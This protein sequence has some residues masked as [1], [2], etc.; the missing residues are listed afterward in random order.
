MKYLL[1]FLFIVL[2]FR[3]LS[4]S[5]GINN[6]G[7]PA[8]ASAM[9]D[10]SSDQKGILIPRMTLAQRNA[11]PSPATGL[12]IYQTDF[13]I[14]FYYYNGSIWVILGDN[15]GNHIATQNITLGT[16]Y[17]SRS[18]SSNTGLQFTA[19]EAMRYRAFSSLGGT[20]ALGDRLRVD[21]NG[22]LVALGQLGWGII[23]QTGGGERMMW[24][25]YK[26]AFRAGGVDGTAW[27][28]ANIGFYS[29]AFGNNCTAGNISSFAG[30]DDS[31]ASG[32]FSFAYGS[33][34]TATGTASIA[35]GS[36]VVSSGFASTGI[37]FTLRSYGD[38]SV[39]MGYRCG[40]LEDYSVAIGYRA[41]AKNSGSFVITDASTTDSLL[42]S[43]NNQ[44]N[45]RYAG[46]YRLFTNAIKTTGVALAAGGNAWG[47]ISD[48][49]VKER[50]VPAAPE[51]FLQKLTAL[52]LGSWNY[53]GQSDPGYRHYG[54]MAQE[55]FSAYGKDAYGSIG[56]DTTLN[57]ADMDGL[58]MILLQGLE[59]RTSSLQETNN[60]LK[61]E[62]GR[63]R[64]EN[65]MLQSKLAKLDQLQQQVTL[66]MDLAQKEEIRKN[67]L[68]TREP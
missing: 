65:E 38:G 14:G 40:A 15:M 45:A 10:V 55:I 32:S 59:K 43:T 26:A 22:G 63:L 28:E 31:K 54:P 51:T 47:T 33:K 52:R 35:M 13:E 60:Q 16:R 23:P 44:F 24:Y 42:S 20:P 1:I 25:P 46:G 39:A 7:S 64:S 48:S 67:S 57:S 8:N 29:V 19:E 12:L 49:T 3:G 50:F 17:I 11:I 5:V 58:M 68:A 27:D 61:E 6:T 62:V 41:V 21:N 56:N 66:L 30:G 4:Q 9:L 53:K 36:N 34:D 2:N 18:G 37:G